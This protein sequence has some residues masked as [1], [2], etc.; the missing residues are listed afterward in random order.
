[1]CQTMALRQEILSNRF[2]SQPI[3]IGQIGACAW[4][5]S[6]ELARL[7]LHL[8]SVQTQSYLVPQV[9]QTPELTTA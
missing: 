6:G 3:R 4:T 2:V 5:R 1:M 7:L 8:D 9:N